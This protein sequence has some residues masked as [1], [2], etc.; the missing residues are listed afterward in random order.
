MFTKLTLIAALFLAI[1]VPLHA[2]EAHQ[3]PSVPIEITDAQLAAQIG[4]DLLPIVPTQLFKPIDTIYLSV[5]TIASTDT[6]GSLGVAWRY[7]YQGELQAVHSEGRELIFS[8]AGVTVFEI[9]KPDG[10]PDGEYSAEIFLNG[11]SERKLKF[12]VL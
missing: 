10:W 2:Q 12:K 7:T 5:S 4:E 6:P 1:T 3:T 11:K 8:G 9:S